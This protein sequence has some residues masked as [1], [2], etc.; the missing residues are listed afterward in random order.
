MAYKL[1][2]LKSFQFSKEM[3]AILKY[4]KKHWRISASP[5]GYKE[6]L[7]DYQDFKGIE[8]LDEAGLLK[9]FDG[10]G[11]GGTSSFPFPIRVSLPH[12]AY[13]DRGQ[14]RGTVE[15]LL[16]A[17]LAHGIFIGMR[18]AVIDPLSDARCRLSHARYAYS[19]SQS[20]NDPAVLEIYRMELGEYFNNNDI[21]YMDIYNK[22][23]GERRRI[24]ELKLNG[25]FK[26]YLKGKGEVT[27]N[28]KD[29]GIKSEYWLM[30]FDLHTILH[31]EEFV[32]VLNSAGMRVDHK[33]RV[34]FI[35]SLISHRKVHWKE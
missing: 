10:H 6:Y 22:Y 26:D 16:G 28:N 32:K 2:D 34:E 19:M 17:V 4:L 5:K 25:K 31:E 14:G 18:L 29:K 33:G 1:K 15:T 23:Q 35:V 11:D 13:D 24:L 8:N 7:K 30:L 12:V 21:D 9:S 20:E 3:D 27:F